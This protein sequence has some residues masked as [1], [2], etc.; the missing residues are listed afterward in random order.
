MC[1]SGFFPG[2]DAAVLEFFLGNSKS[3]HTL[4]FGVWTAKQVEWHH[5]ELPPSTSCSLRSWA[6]WTAKQVEWQ[7][8]ELPPSTSRSLMSW[9]M[10]TAKQVEWQHAELPPSTSC[11]LMSWG[12]MGCVNEAVSLRCSQKLVKVIKFWRQHRWCSRVHNCLS[13]SVC[14]SVCLCLSDPVYLSLSVSLCLCPCLSV[15][16]CQPLSLSASLCLCLCPCPCLSVSVRQSVCLSV[17]L[18]L[19]LCLLLVTRIYQM[20]H[21]IICWLCAHTCMPDYSY[22][23][24]TN[25]HVHNVTFPFMLM[26]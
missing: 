4:Q 1:K 6:V 15:S 12:Y 25:L 21:C 10:W 23:P 18:S 3:L 11:S 14:L 26:I 24:C 19:S 22:A 20:L 17:C 13:L 16:V 2:S 8:A 5:A 9:A 7:H